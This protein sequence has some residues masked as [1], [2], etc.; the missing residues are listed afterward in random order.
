[1]RKWFLVICNELRF[2]ILLVGL[3]VPAA[4]RA[5]L[6]AA[7]GENTYGQTRLPV[8]VTN[9][10]AIVGGDYHN[11]VLRSDGS[12]VAWGLNNQDQTNVPAG[13]AHV[14]AIATRGNHCLA[15][16]ADGTVAT[17][18][19]SY[20]SLTN[21]PSNLAN[22]TAIACG[23]LHN[24]ALKADG[25]VV[26]WGYNGEG[27]TNVP[28]GLSAV[29][30]IAAGADHNL[31]LKADGSV[32][33]WGWNADG[34]TDVPPDLS[35]AVAIAA[36]NN[37]SL[38]LRADGTV[39]AWGQNQYGQTHVPSGLSNV[40]A[41]SAGV[42]HAMALTTDGT[43]VTWGDATRGQSALPLGMSNV[44]AIAAGGYHNLALVPDG[45]VQIIQNPQSQ[46]IPYT[47]NTTFSV[48]A[49]GRDPIGYRWLFNGSPI[50][51]NDI[52]I[53]G[54]TNASFTITGLQFSD[55]G[56]YTVVVSNAF[57][58]VISASALLNVI[59]PPF[60]T[61]QSP[62]R[63][64]RAGT[65]V[66]FSAS[67]DGTPPLNYQWLFNE[68]NLPGKTNAALTLLNVQP[69]DSGIYSLLVTNLYGSTQAVFSLTVTDSP[70]YILRQPFQDDQGV[71][72]SNVVVAVGASATVRVIAKGSLPLSYQWRFNGADLPGATNATLS[73]N[74]LKYEQTGFYN[75][76]VSNPFGQIISGK[77][78]L[79]VLQVLVWS[80]LPFNVPTNV[81]P[82]LT[83][84][85]AVAAGNYHVL[86]LKAD[87]RVVTWANHYYAT[88]ATNVPSNVT[89][90][91]A[92]AAGRNSSMALRANG[93]V[94]V[95]GDNSFGITNVP[96]SVSNVMAIATGGNHCLVL[97]SNGTVFGWGNNIAGQ[98]NIPIGLSNV[99]GIAAG[100]YHSLALKGDGK[101]V[102]W[103]VNPFGLTNVPAGLSNV[104]AIA[105]GAD[106]CL[107]LQSNGIVTAWGAPHGNV[108]PGLSNV[109]AIAAGNSPMVLRADGS[110]TNWGKLGP[111]GRPPLTNVIAI[112][113]APG[114]EFPGFFV[115]V[116]GNGS[117]ALTVQPATQTTTKGAT[118]RLHARA[119]GVQPMSYQWQ[120]N[121]TD[122][123]GA[124]NASLTLANLQ[125]KDT[126]GYRMVAFN[127]LGSAVSATAWVT[128]PFSTNLPAALNATNLTWTTGLTNTAW[129]AQIRETHDGDA[130]A[131][132]GPITHNQ[133]SYLQTTVTGP[134]TVSFW[135]KVSSEEGFDFLKVFLDGNP[136]PLASISGESEW[137]FRSFPIPYGSHLLK[138]TYS[139]DGNVNDGQD[140]GWVD[141]VIFTPDPPFIMQ[142]PGPHSVTARM[143]ANVY[144]DVVASDGSPSGGNLHYH[145]LKNG[146]PLAG[147]TDF[148]LLLTNVTRRDSATY[149]V[150]VSNAGGSVL[151]S[152]ATL[153]VLVPQRV[154]TPGRLTDGGFQ[155]QSGDADG[156]ALLPEDLPAFEVQTS[157]NLVNWA[158]LPVPLVLTNGLLMLTDANGTNVPARFYRMMER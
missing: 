131:Q 69:G 155:I 66:S 38:A 72:V 37:F 106:T 25:T 99:V 19:S 18:G 77:V 71:I 126:G 56:N 107:V 149:A 79:S 23:S 128:A 90:V 61:S 121:G 67:V 14:K 34:Q 58:S 140:A 138:W 94:V 130:A 104:I 127:A 105:A 84:A 39:A 117:P 83:N 49:T 101:V 57:G 41:I 123:S 30:A 125:G 29:I 98:T 157:T 109:V 9:V 74:Q 151:S 111:R 97:R 55:I 92:I 24:L 110:V 21:V 3:C 150:R 148:V 63:T 47:S 7:W 60:I 154:Q 158:T 15:L 52:R 54:V 87:G 4:S 43:V 6:V 96:A 62:D 116:I 139:K 26:A 50:N 70:P 95:W 44:T 51:P 153:K 144:F 120:L 31:A 100:S 124:T 42:W 88:L 141:E 108:P 115:T 119:A 73:L 118:V 12:V 146:A 114:Q 17:W 136:T 91:V 134:G 11:L 82:D 112:A 68:A 59:S 10:K 35:D 102:A 103:G 129:F 152:N 89:N 122:L 36:G 137:A 80:N 76:V 28:T 5:A 2:G 81:P 53:S 85:V 1:M 65:D 75:V 27:E 33:A 8:G 32:V 20:F 147:R 93:S 145:W 78:S 133:Q 22:V 113:S 142:Q 86:A 45:P 64:V 16:K 13:L 156:G 143:G 135:W 132:S 40:S 46:G 48:V